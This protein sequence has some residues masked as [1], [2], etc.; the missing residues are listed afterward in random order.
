MQQ[1]CFILT[2]TLL[3]FKRDHL[4]LKLELG[5][6][7][8]IKPKSVFS[9]SLWLSF[10]FLPSSN[11]LKLLPL[12]VSCW[13][14]K[15]KSCLPAVIQLSAARRCSV[16]HSSTGTRILL[17]V[18]PLTTERLLNQ[19]LPAGAHDFFCA[20]SNLSVTWL[21]FSWFTEIIDI[22][23][24]MWQIAANNQCILLMSS[25]HHLTTE[26]SGTWKS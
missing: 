24:S 10:P 6:S 21:M 9:E 14:W 25:Q 7:D 1:L 26:K 23:C 2:A 3:H 15:K 11:V 17:F 22:F 12:L 13:Y 4:V 18:L 5:T 8:A 19:E 16:Q 20:S